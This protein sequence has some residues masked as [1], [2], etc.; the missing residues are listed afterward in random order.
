MDLEDP[1]RDD[2]DEIELLSLVIET[3]ER[4][5]VSIDPPDPIEAIRFRMDQAWLKAADVAHCFGGQTRVYEVLSGRRPLNVNM[6]R[7]LHEHIGNPAY[8][9]LGRPGVRLPDPFPIREMMK[10]GWL[11]TAKGVADSGEALIEEFLSRAFDGEHA[12]TLPSFRQSSREN[13]KVEPCS[14]AAWSCQQ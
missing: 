7:A 3:H 13:A 2:E 11:P 4:K 9:L 1:P 6:V 14:L 8:I 5:T 12:V 10:R